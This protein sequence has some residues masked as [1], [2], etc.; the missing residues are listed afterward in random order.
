METAKPTIHDVARVAG[1]SIKTVS[2]VL[3]RAPSVREETRAKVV[4]VAEDLN[5]QPNLSARQLA[6]NR[7]FLI[8]MLYDDPNPSSE[9]DYV[10]T[11]Q[12]GSIQACREYGYKLLVNPYRAD[13]PRLIDE[14]I[15]LS[16]QVDGLIVLQPMSDIPGLNDLLLGRNIACVRVSQRL[17]DGV[18]CISVADT[19]AAEAMTEH[20]LGLGHR[21]IGFIVGHPDH[22]QSQDRLVGYRRALE[23]RSLPVED[24][25][26]KQGLF[27]YES[28]YRCARELLSAD[29]APT[30]IFASNDAMAMGVLSAAHELGIDVPA[31]LSVA[32]FD[33]SP[34]ARH[35]WPPLTT[36]RQPIAEVARLATEEL[37]KLLQ[38][39]SEVGLQHCLRAELVF[40]AS[41]ASPLDLPSVPR[42]E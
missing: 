32:G 1:V 23:K 8:G 41:T 17:T 18:P 38:G 5:Y 7:T 19:D 26:V 34:L 11:V 14:V 20:L 42:E 13:S 9:N 37:M 35:S 33:D 22:G 28:G 25:L 3:N 36:V 29:P 40:R 4:A 16:R 2:R 27:D 30:A 15:G 21:R 24:R 39:G 6:S 10:T 12:A 31:G